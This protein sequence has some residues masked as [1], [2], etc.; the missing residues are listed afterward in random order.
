MIKKT[1]L[2]LIFLKNLMIEKLEVERTKTNKQR[3]KLTNN[4]TKQTDNIIRIILII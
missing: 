4:L 1:D 2:Y 3:Y